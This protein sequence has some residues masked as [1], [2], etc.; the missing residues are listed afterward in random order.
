MKRRLL[1]PGIIAISLFVIDQ[2]I[3]ELVASTK[4]NIN[5]GLFNIHFITNT[6]ASFGSFQGNNLAFIFLSLA[7]LGA[8]MF[9][10][11]K[12]HNKL[13]AMILIALGGVLSNLVDRIFRGYVVDYI[14]F[15]WWPVF[16]IADSMI[17]I[18]AITLAIII[19]KQDIDTKKNKQVA[20]TKQR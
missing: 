3:K 19:I 8:V 17:V 15:G 13:H 14:D 6:G 16:N 2:I 1:I 18:G 10:F 11:D 7:V 20:R 4:P 9:W 5:L 12:I